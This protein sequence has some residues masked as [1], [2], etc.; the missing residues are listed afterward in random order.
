VQWILFGTATDGESGKLIADQLG[1]NCIN[2][3]GKTTIEELIAELRECR[4]LL[5]NDTGTMHLATL[6]GVPP[7]RF[8][9][10]PNLGSLGHLAPE[11]PSFVTT[12]NAVLAS[13]ASAR[14]TSAA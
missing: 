10:P 8:S 12:S 11:T 2:R 1:A 14:S 7:S 4:V 13:S 9:V 3:I 6:L 5:T